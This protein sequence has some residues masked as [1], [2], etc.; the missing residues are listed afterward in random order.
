MRYL[1][2]AYVKGAFKQ[3]DFVNVATGLN[4]VEF[5]NYIRGIIF[6]AYN[7]GWV[8][9]AKHND[10][11]IPMGIVFSVSTGPFNLIGDMTWFPWA[12][13]RNRI[14]SA[15]HFIN[16]AR[17]DRLIVWYSHPEDSDF[18][19][20]IA[21]HGISK[22]VGSIDGLYEGEQARFWQAKPRY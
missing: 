16:E 5:S 21:R 10:K 11:Y 17:K 2:A 8:L 20:H 9:E 22:R 3:N 15:V 6:S 13:N 1:W 4:E 12:T 19:V 14:E 18:Y 7:N